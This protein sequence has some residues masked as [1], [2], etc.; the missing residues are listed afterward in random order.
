MTAFK[1]G[2]SPPPVEIAIFRIE[3][4]LLMRFSPFYGNFLEMLR[5][6][7]LSEDFS[8]A[9]PVL[10]DFSLELSLICFCLDCT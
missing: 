3:K 5:V 8:L 1:P 10:P 2:A 6:M 7:A 4:G 9:E